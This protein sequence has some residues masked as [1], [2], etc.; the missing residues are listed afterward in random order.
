VLLVVTLIL[1][2][3]VVGDDVFGV[4]VRVAVVGAV[5]EMV[6]VLATREAAVAGWGWGN[7]DKNI[8]TKAISPTDVKVRAVIILAVGARR[9]RERE[10]VGAR[11]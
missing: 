6:G 7:K 3:A 10:R 1:D 5:S 9:E 4:T 8:K 2:D 11:A